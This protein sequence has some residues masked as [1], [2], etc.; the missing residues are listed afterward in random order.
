[1]PSWLKDEPLLLEAHGAFS[2]HFFHFGD[3][4]LG[5][6]NQ[7]IWQW[8]GLRFEIGR[9]GES[10]RERR[11]PWMTLE[12]LLETIQACNAV[13]ALCDADADH[14]HRLGDKIGHGRDSSALDLGP[15][16]LPVHDPGDLND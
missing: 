12:D 5:R 6:E 16:I 15:F 10:H 2:Q 7:Q 8:A 1:M 13:T 11:G 14:G 4:L 9:E 3:K